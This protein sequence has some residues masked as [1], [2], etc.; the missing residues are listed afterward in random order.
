MIEKFCSCL[1]NEDLKKKLRVLGP[2]FFYRIEYFMQKISSLLI[3]A[4]KTADLLA[5]SHLLSNWGIYLSGLLSIWATNFSELGLGSL[6]NQQLPFILTT[7]KKVSNNLIWWPYR[8]K[9]WILFNSVFDSLF[10]IKP[11]NIQKNFVWKNFA[12]SIT[13]RNK[14]QEKRVGLSVKITIH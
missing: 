6:R 9:M 11:F 3:Y 5:M 7:P 1:K 2:W 10:K 13:C 8:S 4:V 14:S 12:F